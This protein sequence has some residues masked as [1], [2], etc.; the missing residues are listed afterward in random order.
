MGLALTPGQEVKLARRGQRRII[1]IHV[2]DLNVGFPPE[3]P[4]IPSWFWGGGLFLG[5]RYSDR[6]VPVRLPPDCQLLK[7]TCLELAYQQSQLCIAEQKGICLGST[8]QQSQLLIAWRL[9]GHLPC[10]ALVISNLNLG[11]LLEAWR[12]P[13]QM[14]VTPPCSIMKQLIDMF[15]LWGEWGFEGQNT[16]PLPHAPQQ[17]RANP[18]NGLL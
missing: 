14:I 3:V 7:R 6:G 10:N 9:L 16:P 11:Q 17:E 1:R 8:Y 18:G 13:V 4:R 5:Q 12:L 2:F 15:S